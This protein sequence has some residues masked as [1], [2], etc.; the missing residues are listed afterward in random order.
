MKIDAH[1]SCGTE[2]IGVEG[3][4]KSNHGRLK[5][6]A[7]QIIADIDDLL[8]LSGRHGR[9]VKERETFLVKKTQCG[10]LRED[11]PSLERCR[12]TNEYVTSSPSRD[13]LARRRGRR[14]HFVPQ[15]VLQGTLTLRGAR[16][17]AAERQLQRVPVLGRTPTR[18]MC[19][20]ARTL[21]GPSSSQFLRSHRS[22]RSYFTLRI[23]FRV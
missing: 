15:M 4:G 14:H 10:F 1:P 11:L 3:P 7:S 18:S 8:Q 9:R 21:T 6:G 13:H 5:E 20:H 22:P 23:C 16:L 17:K 19:I 12:R 2:D